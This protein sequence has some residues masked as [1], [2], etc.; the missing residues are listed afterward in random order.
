MQAHYKSHTR[1]KEKNSEILT[2]NILLIN[3]L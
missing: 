1:T 3:I 2:L